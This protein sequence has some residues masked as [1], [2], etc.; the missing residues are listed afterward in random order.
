MS[1]RLEQH[2]SLSARIT[3]VFIALFGTPL[4]AQSVP[5]LRNA[6]GLRLLVAN[7]NN[8]TLAIILPGHSDSDRSIEVMFPHVTARQHGSNDPDHLY[9]F[10]RPQGV[11]RPVWR[12]SGNSLEYER[13]LSGGVHFLARATLEDDGVLFH[14]EFLNRSSKD[15]DM[16]YAV[17]HPRLTGIFHDVRLERTYVHHKQGFDLLASETPSRAQDAPQSMADVA[18]SRLFHLERAEGVG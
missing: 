12:R 11:Q 9:L 15:Y 14:Y 4:H 3:C 1:S 18:L 2:R 13:E 17:T 8:P 6:S 10:S 16:I 7:E 5:A